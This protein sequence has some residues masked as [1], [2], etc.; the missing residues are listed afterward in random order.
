MSDQ[1]L[2]E[3]QKMVKEML[4][5]ENKGF[6]DWEI[7]FLDSLNTQTYSFTVKQKQVIEKIYKKKM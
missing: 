3:Y 5:E 1:Q 6:S 2:T 7:D 4:A